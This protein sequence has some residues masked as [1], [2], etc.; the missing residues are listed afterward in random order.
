MSDKDK[1]PTPMFKFS[2]WFQRGATRVAKEVFERLDDKLNPRV[3]LLAI[4]EA[5]G[6]E[7]TPVI[8]EP[9]DECGYKPE[10]FS[11][12][13]KLAGQIEEEEAAK[14]PGWQEP[15][16][17]EERKISAKSIQQAVEQTLNKPENESKVIS[18]C[19]TPTTVGDYK[20]CCVLHLDAEA[21]RPHFS[22]PVEW[23]LSTR[24]AGSLID[25]TA[26]EFLKVCARGLRDSKAGL[27]LDTLGREPEEIL[28]MGGRELMF[29]ATHAT[30]SGVFN[31]LNELSWKTHEG[32]LAGGEIYFFHW[33]DYH[34]DMLV[35]FK[36]PPELR[37]I[38]ATRKVIEMAKAKKLLEAEDEGL[39]LV[40]TGDSINGIG[41]LKEL[42]DEYDKYSNVFIVKFT[43]YHRWELRHRTG[44][45]IMQV[46]N[47]VPSLPS[48]PVGEGKFRDH[49][50]RR[51]IKSSPNE[52]ELWRI[53]RNAARQKHGTMIVITSDAAG[54]ADRLEE[55]STVLRK[56]VPL[57]KEILLMLTSI[58]GAV[59]VDPSGVCHA[60]G[61]I[62]DG[63]AVKGKGD[64]SRGARYNSA[65]RYIHA[66]EKNSE[67]LA[68]VISEDG[69]IN[70]MP[71]LKEKIRR[72][73]ITEH[74]KKLR[75]SVA[76]ETVN[77]KEYY[78]ALD[79]L[80]AHRFYLSQEISDEI[81]EIK[82]AATTRLNKQ[83]GVSSNPQDFK[84][85]KEMSDKF[86]LEE[87]EK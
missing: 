47:G 73:G 84:A 22:L 25:A 31:S 9:A 49:V 51:F 68:V 29:R 13:M 15:K 70:L 46:V 27:D 37:K 4:P 36:N 32:E 52:D 59:M 76:S 19:S 34:L 67:C 12:I 53:V 21:F 87:V 62:L 6:S 79:W 61:V 41:R 10:F 3:F 81:N 20:V 35:R 38:G 48:D 83:Q 75:A 7:A 56:P 23:R 11:D 58:D 57:T 50:R 8:L 85:D 71:D 1:T 42:E 74:M 82:N 5:Q 39:Y 28:R 14:K 63:N 65:I 33:D 64:S 2:G 40:S 78:K 26:V 55:Q 72:S 69:T 43:G 86:F 45:V 54:E 17:G 77:V 80:S 66:A 18:Y 60:A 44:G 16:E 24:I 30:T